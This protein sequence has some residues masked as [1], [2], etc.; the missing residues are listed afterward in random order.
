M[1]KVL[2]THVTMS[3]LRENLSAYLDA[4]EHGATIT[5]TRRGKPSATLSAA[6]A[7]AAA[8]DLAEL[9]QFRDSFGVRADHN[10]ILTNREN[11]RY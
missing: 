10:A 7:T 11:E 9:E 3:E 6:P 4:V 2:P 8:I 5:V 1:S